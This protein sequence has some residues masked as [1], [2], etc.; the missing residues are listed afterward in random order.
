MVSD[1]LITVERVEMIAYQAKSVDGSS[2]IALNAGAPGGHVGDRTAIPLPAMSRASSVALGLT[3]WS[4]LTG[5]AET[6]RLLQPD[7]CTLA[8]MTDTK[9]GKVEIDAPYTLTLTPPG[10]SPPTG[11]GFSGTGWTTVD[12]TQIAPDGVAVDTF[13]GNGVDDR[14]V[15]FPLDRPGRW[16]FALVDA[17]A[18]CRRQVD[19]T[20]VLPV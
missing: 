8:V 4:G 17:N 16:T 7:R 3:L 13:R 15:M 5:C 9:D 12:I 19:V 1:G 6:E 20:V 11:I 10:V 2:A 18:G 14:G